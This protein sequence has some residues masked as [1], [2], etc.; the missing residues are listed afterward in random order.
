MLRPPSFT[1][2]QA[3]QEV[4]E[5]MEAATVDGG[6]PAAAAPKK[7]KEKGPKP[8][9]QQQQP[10]GA[11]LMRCAALCAV[12]LPLLCIASGIDMDPSQRMRACDDVAIPAYDND[13]L[14]RDHRARNTTHE[15]RQRRR[16][17]G[18]QEEG[19]AARFVGH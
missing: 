16:R 18:R 19:D 3:V 6:A 17:Q 5:K 11:R 9:K 2:E 13:A 4:A 14:K 7:Q 10:K 15:H 1:Q 8:E 12:R